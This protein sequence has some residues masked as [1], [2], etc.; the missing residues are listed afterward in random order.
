MIIT[1][2]LDAKALESRLFVTIL[3]KKNVM[4]TENEVYLYQ[5]VLRKLYFSRVADLLPG[6]EYIVYNS[7]S[8]CTKLPISNK[9]KEVFFKYH[10]NFL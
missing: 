8:G 4:L 6:L 1:V 7:F 3:H 10:T 5:T 9:N 2:L